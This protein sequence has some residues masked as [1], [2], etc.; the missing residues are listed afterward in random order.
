MKRLVL[1]WVA[2]LL[3]GLSKE[4]PGEIQRVWTSSDGKKLTGTLEDQG[5]DWVK[6][7]IKDK[8]YKL[9]IERLSR[10]DK[11]YLELQADIKRC[12]KLAVNSSLI[13][14][15]LGGLFYQVDK[16]EP[17]S[18]WTKRMYDSGQPKEL[19]RFKDGKRHGLWRS[20]HEN[21][22][23]KREGSYKD[24]KQNGLW[25][26][27]NENGQK[28]AEVSLKDGKQ[29]LRTSF[30]GNG[31]KK[32]EI[33]LKDG[34]PDGL[35]AAWHANGQKKAEGTYK[36]GKQNGLLRM[37]HMNGR[38]KTEGIFKDGKPDGLLTGWYEDGQKMLEGVLKDGEEISARYWNSI[39]E[40]VEAPSDSGKKSA[41]EQA[42]GIESLESKGEE[43]ET[44]EE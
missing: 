23:K 10:A 21:G 38:K 36:D 31:Q 24:G 11:D 28:K 16:P 5:D 25:A 9:K 27:W 34:K 15:R 1:L 43:V 26:G 13:K 41:L 7:R 3:A 35:W 17:Y 29:L 44:P 2:L 8:I 18:G 30:Y 33:I 42:V 14:L 37:W 40:E 12:L 6:L 19:G 32:D 20:W 22:Q 4:S 39:G